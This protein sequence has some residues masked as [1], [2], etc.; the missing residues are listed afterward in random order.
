VGEAKEN[1]EA[2]LLR[3]KTAV[4]FYETSRPAACRCGGAVRVAVLKEEQQQWFLDFNASARKE[5]RLEKWKDLA[6]EC[7][8]EMTI[9]PPAYRKQFE[10]VFEWL[11]K[12]PCARRRGLGTRLPFAP[13]WIIESLSDSTIYMAFYTII[14]RIRAAGLKPS[15]LTPEFFDYVFLGKG[16]AAEI[17]KK[18]GAETEAL[19]GIRSEF[20][21]WYPNDL[22]HTAVAHVTNHLSFFIFAHVA[23][24]ERAHWPRAISL[25]EMVV[26]EGAKMSKSKGNVVLLNDV[27]R[28]YGADLFRV[29]SVGSAD[30]GST[31]D[32]RKHDIEATRRSL[33]RFFELAGK[34]ID[35]AGGEPKEKTG[36]SGVALSR[37]ES[38][39]RDGTKALEEFRLCDFVQTAFYKQLNHFEDF[40][41]RATENE[42][43]VVARE[44]AARWIALLSPVVPHACEELWE[45]A[46]GAGLAPAG[47]VSLAKWPS[48]RLGLIDPA[49]EA[50]EELVANVIADS[51][52]IMQL[53]KKPKINRLTVIVASAAKTAEA[54]KLVKSSNTPEEIK[55]SDEGLASF[56]RKRFYELKDNAALLETDDY[57]TLRAAREFVGKTMGC[58]V[59]VEREEESKSARA[60]RAMPGK[61][62]VVVE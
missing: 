22:R 18:T 33:G 41:K 2:R 53:L 17:A 1:V 40:W 46:Q 12:R 61:P 8:D 47:F 19:T 10:D 48:A 24:F 3:E 30:F 56:L 27:A 5:G 36:L 7:L 35:A 49:A 6:R 52:K 38:A 29:Y 4:I 45:R 42:K 20:L 25:N 44:C 23:C 26:A 31:L 34:L 58:E 15:Q 37:F 32:F 14:K 16:D 43:S 50:S 21:Y 60:A 39:V 57:E 62:A 9:Y 54:Q 55:A 51:R 59:V 13:D 11:D 28:D